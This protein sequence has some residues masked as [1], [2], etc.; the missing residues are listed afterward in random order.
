MAAIKLSDR[1]WQSVDEM[2]DLMFEVSTYLVTDK[3]KLS[4]WVAGIQQGFAS[5]FVLV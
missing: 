4:R 1:K 2:N 5:Y 3:S